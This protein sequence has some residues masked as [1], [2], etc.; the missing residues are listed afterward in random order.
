MVQAHPFD[1]AHTATGAEKRAGL[2]LL[3]ATALALA[4]S[5][6]ALSDVYDQLL[7]I[8]VS[9]FVESFSIEKPL[10]LWINDGLMA[11]FFLLVGVELKRELLTGELADPRRA[12]LPVVAAIGGIVG[13]ASIYALLNFG[14]AEAMRGWAIPAATDIAFALGVLALL[15]SRAPLSLKVF[16]LAVAILDDL[17]AIII[18]AL[19]Y[20]E[21]LSTAALLA[22]GAGATALFVLNRAGVV[23]LAP[24]ILV[25]AMVWV[26]LLKSGV[27]ATLAGVVTAL[28]IPN[29]ARAG[30]P[31]EAV[32]ETALV[33][34]EHA[35]KPWVLLGIMPV[36]A[37]ANA[38]VDL[39]ALSLPDL[40]DPVALGIATGLFFGKQIGVMLA[41]FVAIRSGLA[42]M[43]LGVTWRQM[44]GV[45]MLAGIGFTM[46]LF[47]GSLAFESADRITDVRLGVLL[48]SLCSAVCGYVALYTATRGSARPQSVA[49]EA[50]AARPSPSAVR[51]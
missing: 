46:S 49:A 30:G 4:F 48:G 2:V 27:H 5:N 21:E 44:H 7:G 23:R 12:A 26:F 24:Y 8:R 6:T 31:G 29:A 36:F 50:T 42:A 45:A 15:G 14:D 40:A 28:F 11:V 34:A 41:V 51:P 39:R 16:L 25:G 38:G 10:L 47:I 18:I 37:F 13:P 3:A 43:P 9:V 33:A 1:T 32:G 19:F 20:T 17:A 35:L 22:A